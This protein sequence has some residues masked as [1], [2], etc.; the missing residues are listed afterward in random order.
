[1]AIEPEL[2]G[3]RRLRELLDRHRIRPKKSLGQ[4]FVLDPNT[5]RKVIAAADLPPDARVV[6]IGAGAG[7]LTMGLAAAA[8]QVVAVEVDTSLLPVLAEVA[9]GLS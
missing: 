4:S 6:E 2:L 9:G 7:S 3:A 8:A 1:M 5:I